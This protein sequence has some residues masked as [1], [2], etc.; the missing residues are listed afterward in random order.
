MNTVE[1]YFTAATEGETLTRYNNIKKN[2]LI[3]ADRGYCSITEINYVIKHKADYV[4]RMRSNSFTLYTEDG[5]KFN[6][7][8]EL[9]S[10]YTPGRKIDLKLFMKKGEDYIP[11]RICAIAKTDED[12]KKSERQM[13]KSNHNKMATDCL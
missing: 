11:V 5:M 12:V 3:V 2:D 1:M 13:K 9:K 4:I 7:T 10:D 8:E 6:L